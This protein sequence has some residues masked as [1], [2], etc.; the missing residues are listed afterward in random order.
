[1]NKRSILLTG[2]LLLALP[3]AGVAQTDTLTNQLSVGINFLSHGEVQGGGLPKATDGADVA[4][5]AGFLMG[6]LRL[7]VGY[8]R[9]G[10]EAKAVIQNSAIW[11]AAGNATV[12][13]YEGW[14]KM[15]ARCGLFAQLGRIA[16]SYDDERIIGPNDFAMASKSHDV[17]LAGY[18]GHGHKVHAIFAWNQNGSNVY[19]NTY[20]VNGGQY[21]KTLQ[22]LWYHY[23]IPRIPVGFS[24]L[25]MNVGMQAGEPGSGDNP[26]RVV[27]QQVA[28]AY[29]KYQPGRFS[30]E[31]SYYRQ[32]GKF[33]NEY[34]YAVPIDAWMA[35]AKASFKASKSLSFELGYDYLSGD[36]YVP[37]PYGG[38]AMVRHDVQK[39]FTPLFGSRTKFYGMLDYFYQSAY[40]N[41]FS[42]G[43]QNAYAGVT[44]SPW[45]KLTVGATYHYLAVGTQLAG[46]DSF[47]GHD[48]DLSLSCRFTKD[49]ILQ[50]GYTQMIGSET[51]NRLKQRETV[52]Q[53]RW[54]WFSLVI[55]PSLFTTRWR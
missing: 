3:V 22:T 40:I 53:A 50:V 8:Q 36:D 20:Y 51:M 31:G 34:M 27:C 10:L 13:L 7:N 4:D 55:S 44:W 16:L 28:G 18:E 46:L 48:V 52:S 29:V 43:L 41:G 12:S 11:G 2:L 30:V 9:P 54:G 37:V 21:Y 15:S 49:I 23:D 33:S 38:F 42:P 47:L 1:M 35:S 32:F 5:V 14:V 17:L 19:T 25:F 39:S 24:L 26:S 45:E 6:R